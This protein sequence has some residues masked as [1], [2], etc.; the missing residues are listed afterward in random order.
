MKRRT[1]QVRHFFCPYPHNTAL[2]SVPFFVVLICQIHITEPDT[3]IY[4]FA[5]SL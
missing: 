5:L 3:L 1:L 4:D 2:F